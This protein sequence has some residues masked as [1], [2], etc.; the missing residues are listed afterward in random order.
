MGW[1][2]IGEIGTKCGDLLP[3]RFLGSNGRIPV[4]KETQLKK[5]K[6]VAYRNI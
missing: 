5:H 4:S 6:F 2:D 3:K 1:M